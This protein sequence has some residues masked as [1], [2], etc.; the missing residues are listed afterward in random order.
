MQW[1]LILEQYSPELIY[2]QGSKNITADSL[3]RLDSVDTPNS[4]KNNIKSVNEHN[5]SQNEV[6]S[7]PTSYKSIM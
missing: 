2:I 6:I 1:R 3:N 5:G 4:V 7:Y